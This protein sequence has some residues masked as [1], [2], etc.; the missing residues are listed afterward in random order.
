MRV[1]NLQT[2]EC[3]H[4][5]KGQLNSV[6]DV[7]FDGTTIAS[8]SEIDKVRIWSVPYNTGKCDREIN[9]YSVFRVRLCKAPNEHIVV[10]AKCMGRVHVH[11]IHTGNRVFAPIECYNCKLS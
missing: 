6:R 3:M 9:V 1:W 11:D 8:C 2:G 10:S 5:L 4:I 7:A